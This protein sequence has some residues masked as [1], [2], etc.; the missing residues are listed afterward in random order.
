MKAP[1]GN[2]CG[3]FTHPC[4]LLSCSSRILAWNNVCGICPFFNYTY[5]FI[6]YLIV[7]CLIK[8]CL[9]KIF[10]FPCE[11]G[12]FLLIDGELLSEGPRAFSTHLYTVQ[13]LTISW[14]QNEKHFWGEFG[15]GSISSSIE[16]W[17]YLFL[18]DNSEGKFGETAQ[19]SWNSG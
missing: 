10:Q 13:C 17:G 15:N 5:N 3:D 11:H 18:S 2:M 7:S 12:L 16:R 9:Q 8:C 19:S 6:L 1:K 14:K 4:K